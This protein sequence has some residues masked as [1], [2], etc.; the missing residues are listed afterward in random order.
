MN[1]KYRDF[2]IRSWE[3]RDRA[4]AFHVIRDVLA[5]YG[6]NLMKSGSK[7]LACSRKLLRCT[8]I[9][10]INRQLVWRRQGAIGF[11]KKL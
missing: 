3:T 7:L 10:D 11:T 8:K 2:L 1:T 5:E 4:D 6:L 9:A